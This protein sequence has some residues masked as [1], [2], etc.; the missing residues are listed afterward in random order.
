[1]VHHWVYVIVEGVEERG[2]RGQEGRHHNSLFYMDDGIVALSYPQ[3]LQGIFITL[4]GLFYRV[5]LRTNVGKTSGMVFHPCQ[6]AVAQYEVTYSQWMTGEGPSYQ[7]RNMGRVKFKECGEDMVIGS[8]AGHMRTQH[9]RAVEGR[10]SLAATP[11]G[12]EPWTY[13]MAFLTV[14]GPQNCLV[15]G[16]PGQAATRTEMWVHFPHQHVRDTVVILE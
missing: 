7:E 3:W 16:C 13:R 9:G 12:K 15:E 6:A 2:E 1:M 5:G 10:R 11:H 8:M 4:V 14:V